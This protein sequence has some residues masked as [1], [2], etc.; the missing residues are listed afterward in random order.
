[1]TSL[2]DLLTA[3]DEGRK[4][5]ALYRGSSLIRR[6][7]PQGWEARMEQRQKQVKRAI[8]RKRKQAR[9]IDAT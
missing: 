7:S 9:A 8:K 4:W 2:D 1:M 3:Q 6:C 5:L